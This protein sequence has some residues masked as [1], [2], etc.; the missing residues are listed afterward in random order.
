MGRLTRASKA[1][2]N[3][4][5]PTVVMLPLRTC[6]TLPSYRAHG[7]A[8]RRQHGQRRHGAVLHVC[9]TVF[10]C[11]KRRV[12]EQLGCSVKGVHL[13]TQHALHHCCGEEAELCR[14]L[15]STATSIH[16]R[17]HAAN[18]DGAMRISGD[19]D[20]YLVKCDSIKHLRD[21][22]DDVADSVGD[23]SVD[24][25]TCRSRAPTPLH[26]P[27]QQQHRHQRNRTS[28]YRSDSVSAHLAHLSHGAHAVANEE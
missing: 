28:Q 25:G 1:A 26:L 15:E 20:I 17:T 16:T 12:I 3:R 23:V 27:L 18:D 21:D 9:N 8:L 5:K 2:T 7:L 4:R 10:K 13:T 6:E 24:I 11:N 19:N 14:R 22:A